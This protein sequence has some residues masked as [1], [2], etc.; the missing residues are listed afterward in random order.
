MKLFIN[1]SIIFLSLI[2]QACSEP[3]QLDAVKK[4]FSSELPPGWKVASFKVEAEEESGSKVEPV[5]RYRFLAEIAPTEDL[6]RKAGT[7]QD[8]DILKQTQK[9]NQAR[10]L[11][12]QAVS[13]L[14]AGEWQSQ[15]DLNH[16][17]SE[18]FGLP[19]SSFSQRY[20]IQG[21]SDYKKLLKNAKENHQKL[22]K[23]IQQDEALLTQHINEFH[24]LNQQLQEKSRLSSEQL[25]SLQQQIQQQR[26]E[27]QQQTGSQNQALSQQRQQS[28]QQQFAEFKSQLDAKTAETEK[29]YRLKTAEINAAR[30]KAR[31][32]RS[33][34]RNSV[35]NAYNDDLSAQRKQLDRA[36]YTTYK[37][38]A[39]EKLKESYAAIDKTNNDELERIKTQ[40]TELTS[41][42][43]AQLNQ[44]NEEYR[45]Q[46]DTVRQQ[47][48][49]DNNEARAGL[50]Q[51]Q[52]DATAKLDNELAEARKIH[53]ELLTNNN[54]QLTTKRN[55]LDQLQRKLFSDK[56]RLTAD[57]QLF[58]VLDQPD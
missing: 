15:L 49:A 34:Q 39:D 13:V 50:N 26:Y 29:H 3:P 25:N 27:L 6:F 42:R 58:A 5:W 57:T 45:Q 48:T 4:Q 46:T 1:I 35:R 18:P 7:L 47:L 23:Q 54:Q 10:Q 22:E 30:T 33:E 9:K 11:H 14:Y 53:Q 55:E 31:E 37:A 12:G 40:E 38:Q 19:A 8:T 20:V 41:Q 43:R 44:F 28:Q 52:Q 32:V 16:R 24:T 21:S 2:L 56:N 36:A 51:Q 17:S